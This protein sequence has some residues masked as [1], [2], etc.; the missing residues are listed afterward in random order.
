MV[1]TIPELIASQACY[2]DSKYSQKVQLV[3]TVCKCI[4]HVQSVS[5]VSLCVQFMQLLC[6]E[7]VQCTELV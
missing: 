4:Q 2:F 5:R 1:Q 3:S 7:L 6:S